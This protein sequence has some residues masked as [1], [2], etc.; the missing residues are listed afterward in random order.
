MDTIPEVVLAGA[1][2]GK[3][4]RRGMYRAIAKRKQ[5]PDTEVAS[6]QCQITAASDKECKNCPACDQ[7]GVMGHCKNTTSEAIASRSGSYRFFKSPALEPDPRDIAGRYL[8]RSGGT[9]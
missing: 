2:V 8:Q 1:L 9:R 4:V 7:L 3:T 5:R 6:G